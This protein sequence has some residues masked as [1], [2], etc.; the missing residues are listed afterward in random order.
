[1]E[2]TNQ[3]V[4]DAF[5]NHL[6]STQRRSTETVRTY[7]Y[8]LRSYIEFLGDRRL[9]AVRPHHVE[10]WA[11]R[12]RL[13]SGSERKPSTSTMRREIVVCRR[14]HQWANERDY[15]ASSISSAFA[16][17]APDR[18]PKPA[19][20]ADWLQLWRS[21]LTDSNRL[22]FGL[23]YWAGL[24]RR[25]IVTLKPSDVEL[26][27]GIM[28]FVRKGGSPEP[29]EY[30][31]MGAWLVGMEIHEGFDRWL[32]IVD[33][34][35]TNRRNLNANLLWWEAISDPSPDCERLARRLRAS[36][37]EAG[38]DRGQFTLHQLRHSAATNLYRSGCPPELIRD[39]LSHSSWNT[40]SRYAKTS[41]QM[42]RALERR[43]EA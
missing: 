10:D 11:A 42:A 7:R 26:E 5:I 41:G 15:G 18:S 23:G 37:R 36:L 30:K 9:D 34:A 19:A 4:V 35:V 2:H 24:R 17:A 8:V 16:P 40:T 13:V 3:Q 21:D 29:I 43:D 28:R 32:E 38:L 22:V 1:M 20:N 33:A 6:E 31:A 14:F 12:I 25:E 39:A 27:N